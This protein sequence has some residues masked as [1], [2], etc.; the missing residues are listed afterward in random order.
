MQLY[1]WR[2]IEIK[3]QVAGLLSRGHPAIVAGSPLALRSAAAQ[4]STPL[5]YHRHHAGWLSRR[6]IWRR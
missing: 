5:R 1:S 4:A 2:N 3:S 6:D